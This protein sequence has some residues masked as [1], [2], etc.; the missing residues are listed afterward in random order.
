MMPMPHSKRVEIDPGILNGFETRHIPLMEII[1]KMLEHIAWR[2]LFGGKKAA[3]RERIRI[4]HNNGLPYLYIPLGVMLIRPNRMRYSRHMA[5]LQEDGQA[6]RILVR[7]RLRKHP[8]G[9]MSRW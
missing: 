8:F 5:W 2:E 3:V 1:L 7:M 9:G 4:L 6:Y